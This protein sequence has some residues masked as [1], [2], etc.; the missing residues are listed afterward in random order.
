MKHPTQNFT[1][2]SIKMPWYYWRMYGIIILYNSQV[3]ARSPDTTCRVAGRWWVCRR[4]QRSGGRG[5][6]WAAPEASLGLPWRAPETPG[7]PTRRSAGSR[8]WA[9]RFAPVGSRFVYSSWGWVTC[10]E[11][12]IF[13]Y[14]FLN[15]NI[16]HVFVANRS[17]NSYVHD[18]ANYSWTEVSLNDN[19]LR[20]WRGPSA[21]NPPNI[22]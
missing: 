12:G 9:R 19:Y 1:T 3:R 4:H 20:A 15:I 21:A 14:G 7:A 16:I 18:V 10:G 6:L 22:V 2:E 17:F 5:C 13:K 11:K 8:G